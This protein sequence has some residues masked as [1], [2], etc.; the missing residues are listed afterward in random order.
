MLREFIEQLDKLP[1]KSF[2]KST[3]INPT[4]P[5]IGVISAQNDLSATHNQ[6]SIV[7]QQVCNGV[8]AAGGTPKVAFVP[9]VESTI[10]KNE[11]AGKYEL[12]IR[13]LVSDAVETICSTGYYDGIVCVASEPNLIAGMLIGVIRVNIP[14]LFVCQGTA[15][16]ITFEN[17]EYGYELGFEQIIKIKSGQTTYDKLAQ[18]EN[19][20]P[21]CSG[22]N[23]NSYSANSFSCI[24]ESFGLSF[25]SNGTAPAGTPERYNIAFETGKLIID[26][27][28]QKCTPRRLINYDSLCNATSIDM[29]CGGSSTTLL[30]LIAIAKELGI[31]N[32]TLKT[33][34]DIGK[35]TPTLLAKQDNNKCMM[36]Q[37]HQAGGVYGIIKALYSGKI[38]KGDVTVG[39]EDTIEQVANEAK[40]Y[41]G[42]VIRTCDNR[43]YDSSR[44]RVLY[45]N[46]ADGGCIV[47]Y[48]STPVF[49]G[50]AKVYETENMAIDAILHRE[51][52]KGDVL[53][54]RGEGPRSCP[55]MREI[56]MAAALLQGSELNNEV[57]LITDG[58][59]SDVFEGFSVGHITPETGEQSIFSVLQDGDEIEI[60]IPKGKITCEI[61]SRTAQQRLR[62]MENSPNAFSNAYLK[63]WAK[64]CSTAS[65]GC[66]LKT[67]NSK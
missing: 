26:F 5:L 6:L 17:A 24:L 1:Q 62:N 32:F 47:K 63:N 11:Y 48:N 55:G 46:V 45:G 41:N 49:S 35:Y 67:K 43:L 30:N 42:E 60:S 19:S 56:Y 33:I 57:A 12:P 27:T 37:F 34:S 10:L 15:T 52:K 22:T 9:S 65:D 3:L 44:M 25:K 50:K 21:I 66:V 4:K 59:I 18:I 8:S 16:P 64:R 7:A 36:P 40:I 51:I 20:Y 13:D 31:K 14:C 23:C 38:I 53:V 54:I 58:R 2:S 61:N 39:L 28:S 29:S